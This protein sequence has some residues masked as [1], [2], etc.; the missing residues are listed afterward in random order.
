MQ[1]ATP[2][3][4]LVFVPSMLLEAWC[5]VRLMPFSACKLLFGT[6]K[7]ELVTSGRSVWISLWLSGQY[8]AAEAATASCASSESISAITN[9]ERT[10]SMAGSLRASAGA[11]PGV[12]PGTHRRD[13]QSSETRP[14][15]GRSP[16]G[17]SR[18]PNRRE[19]CRAEARTR[20]LGWGSGLGGRRSRRACWAP[21]TT[22]VTV[23]PSVV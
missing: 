6:T 22:A 14:S 5:A 7:L 13:R 20:S 19:A 3:R 23:A 4:I 8:S 1:W 16:P 12:S 11:Q 18:R 21:R 15:A 9:A 17:P 10:A 2:S